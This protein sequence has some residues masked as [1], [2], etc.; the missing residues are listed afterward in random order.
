MLHT[1]FTTTLYRINRL[2]LFWYDDLR[3]YTNERSAYLRN[4]RDRIETP[5]QQ[6]EL[7]QRCS[8]TSKV[9]VKQALIERGA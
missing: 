7:A 1:G 5:W 9:D 8:S 4:V 6:W 3:R 2:K